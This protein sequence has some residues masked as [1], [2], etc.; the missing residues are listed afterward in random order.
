MRDPDKISKKSDIQFD[1]NVGATT[2]AVGILNTFFFLMVW[3]SW[4]VH[5]SGVIA[6]LVLGF[7]PLI[8]GVGLL[9]RSHTR[10]TAFLKRLLRDAV[11]RIAF[12]NEGKATPLDLVVALGYS[13]RKAL[14]VLRDVAIEDPD[15][16]E[17]RLNYNTGEVYLEFRDIIKSIEAGKSYE[18]SLGN[19]RKQVR[20]ST[21]EVKKVGGLQKP[22]K[23]NFS[24]KPTF[25]ARKPGKL[26]KSSQP[27]LSSIHTLSLPLQTFTF[28]VLTVDA[29]GQAKSY[30][31]GQARFFVDDLG[32]RIALEMVA[33]PGGTFWM[34]SPAEE[35][36]RFNEEG[37][38]HQ[39]TLPLFFIGKFAVT[40]AQ[41]RAVAALPQVDRSLNPEPSKFVGNTHPVERVSWYDCQ[42]F[43]A[44]LARKTGRLYRLPTE[45]E[46]EYA[47]R[48]ETITPFHFGST[49]TSDFANYNGQESYG[50]EPVG[51]YREETT[52]VGSFGMAN[53]FGLYDMHG[54][55]W[56]WCADPWHENYENAP[57]DGSVWKIEGKDSQKNLSYRVLRGGSWNSHAWYCRSA[58]RD[59]YQP[60]VRHASNGFRVVVSF[61]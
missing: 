43:C 31:E 49:I 53:A 10:K 22:Q 59:R 8:I 6:Y 3:A 14:Q 61:R 20:T 25:Y 28:D 13:S 41:W 30:S 51:E 17:L 18:E 9:K 21:H 60:D 36:G 56:E 47:C 16:V 35:T 38:K 1:F 7:T 19:F 48:A 2:L 23:R 11:R 27:L 52:R 15:N 37:P 24:T 40:Q 45:A 33:I 54:N 5:T 29:A 12:R 42:E 26:Q 50:L 44:R 57:T 55:V 39:V 32:G 4:D 58:C 46:W 34:G